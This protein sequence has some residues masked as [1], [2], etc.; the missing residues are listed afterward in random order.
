MQFV[1]G[2]VWRV[3]HKDPEFI[4]CKILSPKTYFFKFVEFNGF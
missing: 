3:T 4:F 2:D 1:M